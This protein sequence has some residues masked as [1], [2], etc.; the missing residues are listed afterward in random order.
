MP[1][2]RTVL[3][4]AAAPFLIGRAPLV[5]A[6]APHVTVIG[7]G[8]FGGWTAWWL[9]RR[10]ARV[11]IV[12]AWHPSAANVWIAG[13]GSGH[14]FKMGPAPG[15]MLADLV[16]TDGQPDRQFRLSRFATR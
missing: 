2:R 4:L 1:S 9:A 5:R 13:G 7:A 8:A 10:E 15:E 3:K 6:A 16:L 14:G 11:T 12:D